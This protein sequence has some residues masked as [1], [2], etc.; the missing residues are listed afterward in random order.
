M[1]IYFDNDQAAFAPKNALELRRMVMGD[2]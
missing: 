1:F 2:S